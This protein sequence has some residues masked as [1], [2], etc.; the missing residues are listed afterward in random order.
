VNI[1]SVRDHR[2]QWTGYGPPLWCTYDART[3]NQVF[4]AETFECHYHK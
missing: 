1:F 3:T 2:Y 4:C